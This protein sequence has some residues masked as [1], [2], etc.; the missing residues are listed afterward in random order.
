M[1]DRYPV[2]PLRAMAHAVGVLLRTSEPVPG[3][4]S[5]VGDDLL[6]G[7]L[8]IPTP[9]LN[10]VWL[11]RFPVATAEASIDEAIAWFDGLGMPFSWWVGPDS[12]PPDLAERLD[13]RGFRLDEAGVPGMAIGLD[14]LP[15]EAPP[16]GITVERVT[17]ETGFHEI[18]R[19]VVEGFG[20]PPA[21]QH[22]IEAFAA[23]GFDEG[24]PQQTFLARLDGE[25]VGTSLGV[26]A[27]DVLG[28][29]NVATVPAARG[30]GVGRAVTL[31]ALRNGLG[32]GC[33]M[34]VLQASE[35]GHPVYERLGFRD[36]AA[37]DIYVR[38]SDLRRETG[39]SA[40]QDAIVGQAT[41]AG[42][43]ADAATCGRPAA[44]A[45]PADDLSLG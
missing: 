31:A 5:V 1:S 27:G 20:A 39:A 40:A 19:V 11:A 38:E 9:P 13:R 3:V 24:N 41:R 30:R 18:C 25:A 45:R 33:R 10:A 15:D 28:V 16:A 2:E 34:A 26:R 23:L 37:Y 17:D 36:F 32:A 22:A 8:G 21:L 43:R 12:G 14:A 4:A 44:A 42:A 6:M 7:S 29:F 35:M